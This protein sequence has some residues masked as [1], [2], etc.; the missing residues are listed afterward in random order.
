[1][2]SKLIRDL[3]RPLALRL[4]LWYAGI[5]AVSSIAAFGVLYALI[6]SVVRERTDD[7]LEEDVEEFASFMQEGG[8]ERVRSEIE[9]ETSG[10]SADDAGVQIWSGKECILSAGL[11]GPESVPVPND[12][13]VLSTFDLPGTHRARWIEGT[14]APGYAIRVGQ[15]LEA[16]DDFIAD[17]R[18]GFLVTLITVLLVGA[19][20]G[21][22]LARR[23]LR[24][25]ETLTRTAAE[26]SEGAL[27]RRVQVNATEDELGLLARTFNTM[28]DRIQA[29]ITAMREMTDNLAHDLRSPL[30]RIRANSEMALANGGSQSELIASTI[31]ECDRLMDMIDTTLDIAEAESGAA[32]LKLDEVNLSALTLD[33]CDMYKAAAEDQHIHLSVQVP[34]RCVLRADRHRLQRIL[35]NLIDNAIKYTPKNGRIDVRL[36]EDA[37]RVMLEVQ[38]TGAGI[39]EADLPRIFQRFYRGDQSRTGNGTGLGL[40]LALAFARAH[41]GDIVATSTPGRGS[42]FTVSLPRDRTE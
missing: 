39:P 33:A 29:L 15:S 22:F 23:A 18:N 28:L 7:D 35:A 40:S 42:T 4:T 20:V 13:P 37:S 25:V 24:P 14:L 32:R 11:N 34:D 10:S 2:S 21:W 30:A 26:I 3:R 16:D 17:F 5:F 19:P 1:M 31:E 6:V 36:H 38:D 27:S 12:E 8:L 41:G 9:T